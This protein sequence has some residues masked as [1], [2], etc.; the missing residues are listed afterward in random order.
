MRLCTIVLAAVVGACA[1]TGPRPRPVSPDLGMEIERISRQL[2]GAKADLA[3]TLAAHEAIANHTDGDLAL[4]YVRF[5]TGIEALEQKGDQIRGRIREL[6]DVVLPYFADWREDN[7]RIS[8]PGLRERE[9]GNLVA[10]QTRCVLLYR[11]G[12]EARK[13]Y[14]S[15]MAILED[16]RELWSERLDAE[17]AAQAREDAADLG[18]AVQRAHALVDDIVAVAREISGSMAARLEPPPAPRAE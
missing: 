9:T 17:S 2:E 15:L 7:K 1:T 16:H 4:H 10:T 13:V 12:K 18:E 5:C 8:D 3:A 14:R 6:K 11:R